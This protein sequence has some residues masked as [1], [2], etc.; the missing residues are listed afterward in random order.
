[1]P[2][3]RESGYQFHEV[4]VADGYRLI[5]TDNTWA[6]KPFIGAFYIERRWYEKPKPGV[7]P[8]VNVWWPVLV[9]RWMQNDWKVRRAYALAR[10]DSLRQ[11]KQA[12]IGDEAFNVAK[13]LG[14]CS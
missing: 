10:A 2:M 13:V 6:R 5:E 12:G 9:G 3:I 4:F 1:M 7:W 8:V 11:I 14:V